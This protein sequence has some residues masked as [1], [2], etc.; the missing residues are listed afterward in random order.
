MFKMKNSLFEFIM[1][2]KQTK[3]CPSESNEHHHNMMIN[4]MSHYDINKT[5]LSYLDDETKK[6]K[7]KK[8]VSNI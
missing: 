4:Q 3:I 2:I 7:P 1:N 5:T 6:K 8:I